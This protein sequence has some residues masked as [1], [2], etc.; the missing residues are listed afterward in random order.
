MGEGRCG[1]PAVPD[2]HRPG[3]FT[4][5]AFVGDDGASARSR[6]SSRKPAIPPD[7]A[8]AG[9]AAASTP[10]HRQAGG[11]RPCALRRYRHP[12]PIRVAIE[13]GVLRR[14]IADRPG[15]SNGRVEACAGPWHASGG[16][17]TDGWNRDEWEVALDDGSVCRIFQDRDTRAWFMDAVID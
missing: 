8:D 12:V 15:V 2:S 5:E 13:N 3:A 7:Q 10:E 1:S 6:R 4:L 11:S 14:V 17:W 16:W 9:S